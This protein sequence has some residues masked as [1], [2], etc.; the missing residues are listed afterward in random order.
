MSLA[1]AFSS[2]VVVCHVTHV[3]MYVCSKDERKRLLEEA[4]RAAEAVPSDPETNNDNDNLGHQDRAG[5]RR[6]QTARPQKK[7]KKR[8]T[9]KFRQRKKIGFEA[10]G[11]I[12]GQR[13]K[14]I[15]AGQARRMQATSRSG[16][17][18]LPITVPGVL[19]ATTQR[20]HS[21]GD[22]CCCYYWCC[23]CC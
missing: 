4:Q 9:T 22:N 20:L 21:G 5:P 17:A 6:N 11:K 10:M 2:I 23:C 3:C 15:D 7:K 13:W 18:A 14:R 1:H 8:C 16:C 19:G 12:I